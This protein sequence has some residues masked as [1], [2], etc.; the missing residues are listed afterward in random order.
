MRHIQSVNS[1][2]TVERL[3]LASFAV[4]ALIL[5]FLLYLHI[6][7]VH[8]DRNNKMTSSNQSAYMDFSQRAYE[9][10]FHFTGGRNR[11]PLYPWIQAIFYSPEMIDEEFFE[12]GK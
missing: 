12:Q 4:A 9:S 1:R 6:V 2:L 7:K 10:R 3:A 11:M 5:G 8:S